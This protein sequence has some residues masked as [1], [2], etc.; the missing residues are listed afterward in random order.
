VAA[1]LAGPLLLHLAETAGGG[2]LGGLRTASWVALTLPL[3]GA[4]V[5]LALFLLGRGRLQVPD[6][7]EWVD[8]EGPAVQSRQLLAAARGEP[9]REAVGAGRS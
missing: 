9:R 3:G 2:R 6:I 4:A 5:V 7:E 8:G 1:F